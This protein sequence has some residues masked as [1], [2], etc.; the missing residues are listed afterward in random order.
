ML[1]ALFRCNIAKYLPDT[2]EG[3]VVAEGEGPTTAAVSSEKLS[4]RTKDVCLPL[5]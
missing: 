1:H 2:A 4:G 3:V 5:N